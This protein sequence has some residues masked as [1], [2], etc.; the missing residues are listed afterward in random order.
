[1]LSSSAVHS[2]SPSISSKSEAVAPAVE[3][4]SRLVRPSSCAAVT[5]ATTCERASCFSRVKMSEPGSCCHRQGR[6]RKGARPAAA[7]TQPFALR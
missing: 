1:V 2:S 7:S 5:T 6:H 4:P 3:A